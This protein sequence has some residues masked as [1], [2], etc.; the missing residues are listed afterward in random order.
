MKTW[1]VGLWAFTFIVL[2]FAGYFIFYLAQTYFEAGIL[3][4]NLAIFFSEI[5]FFIVVTYYRGQFGESF[6]I[7]HYL[8]MMVLLSV[9]AY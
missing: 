3:Y 7:H 8:I 6:H 1:G 4:F 2:I 9:L 5:L